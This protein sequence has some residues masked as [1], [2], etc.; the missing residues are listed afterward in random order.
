MMKPEKES[1]KVQQETMDMPDPTSTK[2]GENVSIVDTVFDDDPTEIIREN[3]RGMN[4]VGRMAFDVSKSK[5]LKQQSIELISMHVKADTQR[6]R[7]AFAL[8]L[9]ALQIR[10]H[11]RYQEVVDNIL[12]QILAQIIKNASSMLNTLENGIMDGLQINKATLDRYKEQLSAGIISEEKFK[13]NTSRFL[14]NQEDLEENIRND[15]M[16][17]IQHQ[18]TNLKL[19]LENFVKEEIKQSHS[20]KTIN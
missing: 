6:M 4:F 9:S 10:N 2:Q 13:K 1:E 19:S 8:Q 7:H 18:R 20:I 3:L 17:M 16:S 5:E 14:Q 11:K 12:E 15:L